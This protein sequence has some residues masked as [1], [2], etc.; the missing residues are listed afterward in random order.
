MTTLISQRQNRNPEAVSKLMI[1]VLWNWIEFW[2]LALDLCSG[3]GSIQYRVHRS[4]ERRSYEGIDF[5]PQ[6]INIF[7]NHESQRHHS[8][9]RCITTTSDIAN[10]FHHLERESSRFYKRLSRHL[11]WVSKC[12]TMLVIRRPWK[13]RSFLLLSPNLL[14]HN[15]ILG[16]IFQC[17]PIA[18]YWFFVTNYNFWTS[19]EW[20]FGC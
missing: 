17:R 8:L 15:Y 20:T 3:F 16:R 5:K 11:I 9:L 12:F 2:N 14:A 6:F 1:W 4:L 18:G 7:L 10:Q 13:R 19:S